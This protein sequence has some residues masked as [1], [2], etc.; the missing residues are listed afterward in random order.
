MAVSGRKS[1][2]RS[3]FRI[4]NKKTESKA[5]IKACDSAFD[6]CVS[7]RRESEYATEACD[8]VFGAENYFIAFKVYVAPQLLS[9][10]T[11]EKP[12]AI[13]ASDSCFTV[14]GVS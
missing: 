14:S 12:P 2:G 5:K 8:I 13:S 11:E 1:T 7:H 9:T 6:S 4:L 10:L 3:I